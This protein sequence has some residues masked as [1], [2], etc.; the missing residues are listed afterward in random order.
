MS[1]SFHQAP[2]LSFP[3]VRILSTTQASAE[4]DSQECILSLW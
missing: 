4:V 2:I 3:L 1:S